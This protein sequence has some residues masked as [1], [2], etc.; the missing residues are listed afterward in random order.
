VAPAAEL[1]DV[2]GVAALLG[3]T[4]KAIRSRVD[5]RQIPYRRWGGRIIF[6]R[7]EVLAFIDS[8]PGVALHELRDGKR[9]VVD[10]ANEMGAH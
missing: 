5:R 7:R 6:L 8:L 1:L 2:A 10:S 3:T 4:E 9:D